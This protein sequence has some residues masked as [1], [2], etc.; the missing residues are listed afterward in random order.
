VDRIL[1]RTGY[2]IWLHGVDDEARLERRFDT[3]GCV[4][5]SNDDI[6]SISEF[7]SFRNVPFVIVDREDPATP[8]GIS[9][10]GS[11]LRDRVYAWARAWSS[12][13]LEA[14]MSFYAP[15][16]RSRNM[17]WAAWKNFKAR[18]KRN[19]EFIDVTVKDLKILNHG[20]YSVAIFD[21]TYVSDRYQSRSLKRLYLV[22]SGADAQILAEEV[23]EE[24]P[25]AQID[26][27][28]GSL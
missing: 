25:E 8:I 3:R 24:K 12:K 28:L 10:A 5:T 13:D 6:R 21:Q 27:S 9:P 23:A 11:A 1:G 14:Y 17:D 20:K 15:E 7:L 16:F 2:G 19:Y 26:F 18:L 4:A 22:G